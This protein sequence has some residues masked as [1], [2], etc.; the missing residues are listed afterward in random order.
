LKSQSVIV[1]IGHTAATLRDAESGILAGAELVTHF[2]NAMEK[3]APHSF[4]EYLLN[5]TELPVELILDGVHVSEE[6][7][8]Q[9]ITR[10]SDRTILVTDAMSAAGCGDGK[11]QIGNLEVD[12]RDAIARLESNGALAGSTLTMKRAFLLSLQS[13]ASLESAVRMSSFNAAQLLKRDHLGISV[14]A[15][16]DILKFD[17]RNGQLSVLEVSP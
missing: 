11:Y 13:G 5:N 2:T 6:V 1:A 10:F 12:V 3:L 17:E 16:A 7:S 8:K 15:P 14:G 4:A 9:L